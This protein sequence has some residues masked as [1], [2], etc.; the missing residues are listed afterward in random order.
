MSSGSLVLTGENIVKYSQA[1]FA[2][3][4]IYSDFKRSGDV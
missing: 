1:C 2:I 4:L 3:S